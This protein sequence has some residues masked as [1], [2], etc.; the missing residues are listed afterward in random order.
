MK[1]RF[2]RTWNRK[3]GKMLLET[4]R[5]SK[6]DCI[7]NVGKGLFYHVHTV[8]KYARYRDISYRFIVKNLTNLPIITL[9]R[10][11]EY[12][13]TELSTFY[14]LQLRRREKSVI[15]QQSILSCSSWWRYSTGH[16][17]HGTW[18]DLLNL[19]NDWVNHLT[20][21]IMIVKRLKPK[22]T[23][24]ICYKN[25][26]KATVQDQGNCCWFY[27]WIILY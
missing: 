27:G 19:F 22:E 9:K 5:T 26:F 21:G 3:L 12:F 6:L 4:Q 1:H 13:F 11:G 15:F 10:I 25:L 2:L 8:R 17:K 7:Q 20:S 24:R 18:N 14:F 23:I 16:Y